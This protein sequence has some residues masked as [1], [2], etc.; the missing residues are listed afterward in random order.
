MHFYTQLT[1]P[2]GNIVARV[3]PAA[4]HDLSFTMNGGTPG[5]YIIQVKND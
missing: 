4:E 2:F 5:I 3:L 1:D